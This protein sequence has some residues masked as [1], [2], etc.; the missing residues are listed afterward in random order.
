MYELRLFSRTLF[1]WRAAPTSL[2]ISSGKDSFRMRFC[3]TCRTQGKAR[4]GAV[5][6]FTHAFC[7]AYRISKSGLAFLQRVYKFKTTQTEA[8]ASVLCWTRIAAAPQ[9]QVALKLPLQ[10]NCVEPIKVQHSFSLAE[11]MGFEP[12]HHVYMRS[13]PLAGEPL[14][15]LGYFS[16]AQPRPTRL[17]YDIIN[18]RNSQSLFNNIKGKFWKHG[19]CL[20]GC[21]ALQPR[22]GAGRAH[23][24]F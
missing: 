9:A 5:R 23:T 22:F 2:L 19:F 12:M 3:L 14:E 21:A 8:F 15:P 11:K 17:D 6:Y 13:T 10:T 18:R 4:L 20:Q 16:T 24:L 7:L 1:A